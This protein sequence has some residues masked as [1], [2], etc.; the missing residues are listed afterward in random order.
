MT[1]PVRDYAWGSTTQL[2]QFLDRTPGGGPEAELWIG[3][4]DGDPSCLPDGR[5]LVVSME[6]LCVYR[7]EPDGSLVMHADLRDIAKG[8]VNDMYVDQ[9]GRAYVGNF[10]FDYHA[11]LKRHSNSM[12]YAPPG[13]PRAPIA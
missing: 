1:N 5:M 12:L 11:F 7:L 8:P 3:A 9:E 6:G 13:P 2:S 4:H 10:G